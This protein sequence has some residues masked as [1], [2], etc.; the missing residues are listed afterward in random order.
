MATSKTPLLTIRQV[1]AGFAISDMTVYTYRQG[2]PTKDPMPSHKDGARVG[3]KEAEL[4]KWGKKYDLAWDADAAAKA[5]HVPATVAAKKSLP[6]PAAK[7]TAAKKA[8]PAKKVSAKV[9]PLKPKA[10]PAQAAAA[11]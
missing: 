7:K 10:Q 11:G 1:M 2:T 4:V 6:K 3:F 5:L 9:V 8:A